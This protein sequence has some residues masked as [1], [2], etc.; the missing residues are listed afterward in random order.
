[1]REVV[2]ILGAVTV[3]FLAILLWGF[4]AGFLPTFPQL[5]VPIPPFQSNPILTNPLVPGSLKTDNILGLL[6]ALLAALSS[7]R[8]SA[9]LGR[10][11]PDGGQG[12][13][14]EDSSKTPLPP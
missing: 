3:F 5:S 1:M 14:S 10:K 8:A 4:V 11:R 13:R 2:A 12:G 6:L 7:Y 9:G